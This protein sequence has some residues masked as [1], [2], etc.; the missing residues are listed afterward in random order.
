MDENV[1]VVPVVS[2]KVTE[3]DRLSVLLPV[4]VLPLPSFSAKA[5]VPVETLEADAGY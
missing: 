3:T 5:T 2:C 1:W 4:S